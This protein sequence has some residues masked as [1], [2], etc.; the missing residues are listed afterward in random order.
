MHPSR[1][2]AEA[3]QL[4]RQLGYRVREDVLEGA[5]GGHCYYHGQKWLLLDL[6]QS[7]DEQLNDVLDALRAEPGLQGLGMSPALAQH[8]NPPLTRV[9]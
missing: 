9:A 1:M 6:T 3:I 2:L 5:G 8:L 7:T 4:A